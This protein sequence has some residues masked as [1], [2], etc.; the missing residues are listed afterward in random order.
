MTTRSVTD[1]GTGPVPVEVR[2]KMRFVMGFVMLLVVVTLAACGAGGTAEPMLESDN[3]ERDSGAAL[4]LV[5]P[6]GG[7]GYPAPVTDDAY[8]VAPQEAEMPT[9]YPEDTVPVPAAEVDLSDVPETLPESEP[10]VLPAPGRPDA[11]LSPGMA[12]LLAA[13]VAD[14]SEQ[15]GISRSDIQLLSFEP[16][17]WPNGALGCPAEGMAYIEVII[18]GMQFTL[19][20]GGKQYTYHTD[21]DQNYVQCREGKPISSGSLGQ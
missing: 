17:V 20:A 3:D 21:S 12:R 14:L 16:M 7:D 18:E 13:I 15:T 19:E 11:T 9:G 4:I 2:A 5:T 10:Q 6:E 8:P 1:M